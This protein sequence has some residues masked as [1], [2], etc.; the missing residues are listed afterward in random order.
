MKYI[1]PI[2][3]AA[4]AIASCSSPQNNTNT[5]DTVSSSTT[6]DTIITERDVPSAPV[7]DTLRFV[8]TEGKTNLDSTTVY[9]NLQGA[10]VTGQM[11]WTPYEKD[12]RKG[13]LKGTRSGDMIDATWTFMQEGMTDT[14]ALKFELKNNQLLQ[15]PL[16]LN[17]KTGREQTDESAD[18][19]VAYQAKK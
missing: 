3:M 9:L 18:Y 13:T 11:N 7:H 17:T 5:A 14:L 6:T 12:S 19:T 10:T 15:K 4:L 8:R 16:K 2:C 1:I